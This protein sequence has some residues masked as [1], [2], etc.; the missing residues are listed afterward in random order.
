MSRVAGDRLAGWRKANKITQSDLADRLGIS[1]EF[2]SQ[3][4]T[5]AGDRRPGLK[6]AVAIE[7]ATGG[8]VPASLWIAGTAD[9][10]QGA[11]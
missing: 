7:K 10:V 11:A 9:E 8:D 3:I 4:E 2:V 5:G 1:Q 6:L